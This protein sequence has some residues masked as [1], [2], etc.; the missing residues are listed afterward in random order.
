MRNVTSLG[1][2]QRYLSLGFSVIPVGTDKRPLLRWREFQAR[3]AT[4]AE[5]REWYETWP[6]AGAAIVCGSLSDVIVLDGDPRNGDGLLRLRPHLPQQTPIA[7]TGGGGQH[8][9]FRSP[10]GIRVG[11]V[12]ALLPGLD[13]QAEKSFVLAPPSR[14]PSGRLYR[15]L[16]DLALGEVPLAPLPQLIYDLLRLRRER[17]TARPARRGAGRAGPLTLET[18]LQLLD[19]VQRVGGQWV[20]RCPVHDDQEPSLSLAAGA[21]GPLLAYCHAGCSF[22]DI[23]HALIEGGPA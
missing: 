1:A 17:E 23:V 6:G 19:G 15:W 20:A 2:A 8:Y 21:D 7:E 14:H 16:P 11:K 10:A 22:S 12:P 5:V 18:A 4:D 9:Y 13:L 3:R